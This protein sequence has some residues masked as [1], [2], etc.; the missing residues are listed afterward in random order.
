MKFM[1]EPWQWVALGMIMAFVGIYFEKGDFETGLL[2][3]ICMAM[4]SIKSGEKS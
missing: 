2:T 4:A 3:L 1:N